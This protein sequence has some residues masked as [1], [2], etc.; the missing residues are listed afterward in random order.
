MVIPADGG[1][2]PAVPADH[3]A[4]DPDAIDDERDRVEPGLHAPR[5]GRAD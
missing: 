3:A 2:L 1:R 4:A 5:S